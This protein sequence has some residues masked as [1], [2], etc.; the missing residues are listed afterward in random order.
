MENII[1]VK[2]DPRSEMGKIFS[3]KLRREGKVPAIIYGDNKPSI[4]IS[5]QTND[6]KSILRAEK[7][8]NTVLKIQKDDIEMDAML[9]EVQYNYLS[10]SIIHADF[11][12]VDLNKPVIVAVPIVIKGESI[13]VKLEDGL[14][15]F[16]TREIQIKCMASNIPNEFIVDITNLHAGNSV[17]AENLELGENVKLISDPH[18]VICSVVSKSAEVAVGTHGAEAAPAPAAAPAAKT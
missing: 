7:G 9:K 13:G 1:R 6:L 3:K 10:D 2:A 17:K 12:R 5:V 11:I 8:A 16:N 14:F 15:D 4:P 18:R